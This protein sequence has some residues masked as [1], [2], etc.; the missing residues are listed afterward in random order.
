MNSQWSIIGFLSSKTARWIIDNGIIIF[1][2]VDHIKFH[3]NLYSFG[4]NRWWNNVYNTQ[5]VAMFGTIVWTH[6]KYRIDFSNETKCPTAMPCNHFLL[7]S[8]HQT[9][10]ISSGNLIWLCICVLCVSCYSFM[11][12]LPRNVNIRILLYIYVH[13]HIGSDERK[14]RME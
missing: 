8:I 4:I 12:G 10:W 7:T 3:V 14:H 9:H 13:R 1:A 11:R 2:M 6:L 5:S